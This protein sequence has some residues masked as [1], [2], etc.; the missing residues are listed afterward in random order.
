MSLH[1]LIETP[2]NGTG[3]SEA[4]VTLLQ[5]TVGELEAAQAL[6]L[7]RIQIWKRQQ[8]LAGNGAP[9]EE[10]LAPLQERC[11][12]LVDIYSQLQQEVG[13]AGGE[14]D[15]KT[16]AALISRL[17]EV[18]RTLVTSSFLVEKQPP[19][20]EDSDQVPGRSSI[21]AGPEVPGGPSQA[22][23]GQ[24]RH[25]HGEAGEGA[26]HAPG[27]RSWSR[28]HRRNHQQHRAPG[29]QHS[30]ELLLCAVQEP[31]SEENQAV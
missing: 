20:S 3:P 29:E 6:V 11:E 30:W 1:S 23:A 12:S 10:S 17:D 4:L 19:G 13:A 8:Q 21:P 24:G 31:A 26:E 25:G 22:S 14:L 15:P 9:F 18:L 28:K 5:E 27:A 7:K 16:R 2:T